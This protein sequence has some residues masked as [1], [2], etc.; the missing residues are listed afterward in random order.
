MEQYLQ[1]PTKQASH[2]EKG[3]IGIDWLIAKFGF[4][5][6]ILSGIDDGI[7]ANTV[8]VGKIGL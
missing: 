6:T 2:T 3:Q 5:I 7:N 4:K 8:R 1:K